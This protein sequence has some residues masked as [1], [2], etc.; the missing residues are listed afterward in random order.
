M[1]DDELKRLFNFLSVPSVSALPE[2]APD[3]ER[4]AVLVRDEILRAGGA[5][6]VIQNGGHPLVV[7]DVAPSV[8]STV[9]VL[10][11]GHYDVQPIGEPSLW[12]NPPFEPQV[13]G[14]HLY[15]RGASDDKGNMFA[16]LVAI[17]RLATERRLP[18]RVRFLIE[19]EEES[20][21]DSAERWL[22]ADPQGADCSLIYD[23]AMITPDL[24]AVYTGLRGLLYRRVRVWTA[25]RDG[26]SG[27]FGGAALNATHAL[28]S[29]L[30]SVGAS[31]GPIPAAL[32]AGAAAP[33]PAER[34]AWN[35]LPSGAQAL[36]EG[37]LRPADGAAAEE[38][39]LRTGFL[40]SLDVHGLS[41]GE[42]GAVKTVIPSEATATLSLRLAPGQ[43][44]AEISP[45]FDRLLRDAAPA[46][47]EIEV[48]DLGNSDPV[49]IPMENVWLTRAA[50]GIEVA[51]GARPALVRSGGSIPI[52]AHLAARGIT[53]ILTGCAL[54]DDAIHAPNE[55]MRVANLE[56]GVRM[57]IGILEALA[58]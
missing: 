40:P 17:Q 32:A 37:G 31:G 5:A 26:H 1:T 53:P 45:V 43:L 29:I 46:G 58:R 22:A 52:M 34:A 27:I 12:E 56:L 42:P 57:A 51:I 2:H 41:S 16:L 55:R 28:M 38:F 18:V 36:A 35:A 25:E 44:A 33:S 47:C 39:D 23:G 14:A 3:M 21:G 7:G 15:A 9:T 48:E 4:A 49:R 13:R 6:E 8:P 54:P 19:G 24:P 10:V 50:D 30:A 20:G 11:Y